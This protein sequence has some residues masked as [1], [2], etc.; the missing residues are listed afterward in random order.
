MADANKILTHYFFRF[1]NLQGLV[2]DMLTRG[3]G[4]KDI[5]GLLLHFLIMTKGV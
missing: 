3:V 2:A 1:R 5:S 4:R